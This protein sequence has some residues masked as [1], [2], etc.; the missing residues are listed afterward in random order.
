MTRNSLQRHITIWICLTAVASLA[1]PHNV[2]ALRAENLD[3]TIVR[4]ELH[5]GLEE[6]RKIIV[7]GLTADL[8]VVIR[9]RLAKVSSFPD[10]ITEVIVEP[11]RFEPSDVQVI[12]SRVHF[13]LETSMK[14]TESTLGA[15]QSL[16]QKLPQE[17]DVLA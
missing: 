17:I 9:G 16:I 15:L 14:G 1:L 7:K 8:Q 11:A 5:A 10:W 12:G 3:S 13:I 6:A 4:N 2:F